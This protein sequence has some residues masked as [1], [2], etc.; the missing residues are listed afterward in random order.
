MNPPDFLR[1]VDVDQV[2]DGELR[3]LPF[4]LFGCEDAVDAFGSQ[5]HFTPLPVQGNDGS[6]LGLRQSFRDNNLLGENPENEI[7]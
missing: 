6:H 3:L 4:C 2:A 5:H 7:L 1:L